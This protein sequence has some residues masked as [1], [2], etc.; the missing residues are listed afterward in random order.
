MTEDAILIGTVALVWAALAIVYAVVPMFDMPD[1]ARVWGAGAV[2]F[3]AMVLLV[4]RA[5]REG[6]HRR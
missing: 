5:E 4:V 2:L 3:A 1:S 6:R